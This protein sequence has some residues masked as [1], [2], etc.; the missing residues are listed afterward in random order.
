MAGLSFFSGAVNKK[1]QA[2][3]NWQNSIGAWG[4]EEACH[5]CGGLY[6]ISMSTEL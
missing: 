4:L 2:G 5:T 6:L 1:A 3:L